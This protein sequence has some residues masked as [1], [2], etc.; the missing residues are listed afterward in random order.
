M[1]AK[2]L[3]NIRKP[4]HVYTSH[5]GR[6]G[7]V[8][9]VVVK[10]RFRQS[11][12]YMP[13]AYD[14]YWTGKR[15]DKLGSNVQDGDTVGYDNGG[16]PARTIDSKWKGRRDF[17]FEY[18]TSYHDI[19]SLDKMTE[20]WF[21][22]SGDYS[23]RNKL[24]R[25]RIAKRTGELFSIMPQGYEPDQSDLLR[26]GSFP[27]TTTAGGDGDE[28]AAVVI[29]G[30]NPTPGTQTGINN[31]GVSKFGAQDYPSYKPSFFKN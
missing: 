7:S 9:D 17:K 29:T 10:T 25:P 18:G 1:G 16:G 27:T 2:E 11:T 22:W 12:P 30:I 20:P 4:K 28:E 3:L 6:V 24:A 13:W 5:P 26:G 8:G 31:A 21:T 14:P 23:W 15:A 19:P